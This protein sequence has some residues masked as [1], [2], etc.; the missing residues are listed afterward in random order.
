MLDLFRV[1]TRENN[2]THPR[3][4]KLDAE[5]PQFQSLEKALGLALH[6]KPKL[7]LKVGVGYKGRHLGMPTERDSHRAAVWGR[8]GIPVAEAWLRPASGALSFKARPGMSE[9]VH[10]F[11]FEWMATVLHFA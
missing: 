3:A 10:E 6:G 1:A 9:D 11:W 8:I 4:L 7:G 5:S 2:D